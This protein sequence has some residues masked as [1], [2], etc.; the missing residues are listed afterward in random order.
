MVTVIEE[1]KQVADAIIPREVTQ[2]LLNLPRPCIWLQAVR[3]EHTVLRH[4]VKIIVKTKIPQRLQTKLY[5]H[6]K[7]MTDDIN[8]Y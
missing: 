4:V 8:R 3:Y 1:C 2:W 7:I 6:L 5:L